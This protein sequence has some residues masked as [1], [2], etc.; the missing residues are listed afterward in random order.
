M[1]IGIPHSFSR[2]QRI[3][4]ATGFV[5]GLRH[6]QSLQSFPLL[7]V[8]SRIPMWDAYDLALTPWCLMPQFDH[9][10]FHTKHFRRPKHCRLFLHCER[11]RHRRRHNKVQYSVLYAFV[12]PSVVASSACVAGVTTAGGSA[13]TLVYARHD[14]HANRIQQFGGSGARL[15]SR[16]WW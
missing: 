10:A 16:V 9:G 15:G 14:H 12:K 6:Q 7:L 2:G 1:R 3:P 5:S 13:A 11:L 4:A 8:S